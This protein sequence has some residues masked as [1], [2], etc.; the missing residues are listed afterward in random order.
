MTVRPD[1][2]VT[3]HSMIKGECPQGF[4]VGDSWTIDSGKTPSGMCASAYYAVFP[5]IRAFRFG[6]EVPWSDD[7][8]VAHVL[9][10]DAKRG[11]VYE[12]KKISR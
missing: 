6:G 8:N 1:V 10:P 5:F 4:K 3:V 2:K 11:V 7:K 9:C 12:V